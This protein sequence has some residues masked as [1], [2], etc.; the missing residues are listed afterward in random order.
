MAAAV[1]LSTEPSMADFP[2]T[3]AQRC[4]SDLR[5]WS[6]P[7]RGGHFLAL[8]ELDLMADELRRFFLSH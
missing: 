4:L 2:R 8:E 7:G 6:E 5:Q 1:T 3:S